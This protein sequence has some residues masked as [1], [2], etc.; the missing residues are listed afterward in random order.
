VTATLGH[1]TPFAPLV[2]ETRMGSA[3]GQAAI[4]IAGI[5]LAVVLVMGQISLATTKGLSEHLHASVE[6]MTEGN[7]TMKSVIERAAPSKQLEGA[8]GKQSEALA[9]TRDDM[10]IANAQMSDMARTTGSLQ[11]VVGTMQKTSGGLATDVGGIQRDTTSIVSLLGTLPAAADK[12]Q[13]SMGRIGTDTDA[14]TTELNAIGT[15]MQSY[16]LPQAQGVPAS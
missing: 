3:G 15:K 12:T 4:G 7:E 1:P 13:H 5:V 16:G 10:V 9:R 2:D 11:S 8:I 14:L 6:H